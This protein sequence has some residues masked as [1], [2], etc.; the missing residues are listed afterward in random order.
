[1]FEVG[2]EVAVFGSL[3]NL[4]EVDVVSHASKTM[5]HV[6]LRRYNRNTGNEVGAEMYYR[7]YILPASSVHKDAIRIRE[8]RNRC[9]NILWSKCSAKTCEAVLALLEQERDN[10]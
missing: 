10:A 7:N 1:M 2:D 4:L 9:A 3:N 8:L 6:G 5:V